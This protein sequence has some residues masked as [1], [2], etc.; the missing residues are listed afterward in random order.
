MA[1]GRYYDQIM[2]M[3][4]LVMSNATGE[5]ENRLRGKAFEC[6]SLLGTA[7][8]KEKFYN[9]AKEAMQAMYATT[10]DADDVQKDYIKEASERI[11][12]A[13]GESFKEFLPPLLQMIYKKLDLKQLAEG[14]VGA[15]VSAGAEDEEVIA[16]TAG[17]G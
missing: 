13:L 5:K 11:C 2:P 10:T 7:V 12:K 8:G 17:D 9:D 6:I 14:G 4:K 16:V 15:V 3:L 1:V